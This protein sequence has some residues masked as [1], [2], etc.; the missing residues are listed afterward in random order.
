MA[1]LGQSGTTTF[2]LRC[3]SFSA[4]LWMS[5]AALKKLKESGRGW[6]RP[7]AGQ[8]R[9]QGHAELHDGTEDARTAIASTVSR[10]WR[11]SA[12]VNLHERGARRTMPRTKRATPMRDA[13]VTRVRQALTRT[14]ESTVT[15][16]LANRLSLPT[17]SSRRCRCS[18]RKDSRCRRMAGRTQSRCVRRHRSRL[19]PGCPSRCPMRSLA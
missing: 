2:L 3:E 4:E 13:R 18:S 6:V 10:P 9:G 8:L 11:A 16:K 19:A 14:Q 15:R 7:S 12:F 17:K 5:S 1:Q